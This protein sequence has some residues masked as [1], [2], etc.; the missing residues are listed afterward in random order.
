MFNQILLILIEVE[1]P[2][3][4]YIVPTYINRMWK[5]VHT[6]AMDKFCSE[7]KSF[8]SSKR[9]WRRKNKSSFSKTAFRFFNNFQIEI[10]FFF[11]SIKV[12]YML[13]K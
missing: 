7:T 10:A 8:S 12:I 1:T 4:C 5:G 13:I 11:Q 3:D 6:V 2:K 9:I